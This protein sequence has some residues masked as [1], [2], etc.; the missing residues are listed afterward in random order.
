MIIRESMGGPELSPAEIDVRRTL[1]ADVDDIMKTFLPFDSL[2]CDI[3]FRVVDS[4]SR[5]VYEKE[6]LADDT[7]VG[8]IPP[9]APVSDV[10]DSLDS[11]A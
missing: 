10:E 8:Q 5:A 11:E 9:E 2:R 4:V 1:E 7:L 6:N 3:L